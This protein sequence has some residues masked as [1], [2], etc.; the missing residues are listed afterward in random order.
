M[1]NIR[2]GG[3]DR[4]TKIGSMGI[5]NTVSRLEL[6]YPNRLFFNMFNNPQG[7]ASIQLIASLTRDFY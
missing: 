5:V 3:A 2:S 4:E 6:M 7:G 1:R